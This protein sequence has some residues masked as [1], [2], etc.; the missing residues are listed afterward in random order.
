MWASLRHGGDIMEENITIIIAALILILISLVVFGFMYGAAF[1]GTS[2]RKIACGFLFWMPFGNILTTLTHGC[3][4]I[5][6]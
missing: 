1:G 4:I 2:V 5:P 3:A 6:A